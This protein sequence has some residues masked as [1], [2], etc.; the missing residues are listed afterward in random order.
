MKSQT[1]KKSVLLLLLVIFPL[2]FSDC[3]KEEVNTS[4]ELCVIDV[5]AE[6]DWDYWVIAKDGSNFFIQQENFKPITI[7]YQPA[8]YMTKIYS[9]R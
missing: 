6:T 9:I 5:S 4:D 1:F 2:S 7:Y 3:D 8:K